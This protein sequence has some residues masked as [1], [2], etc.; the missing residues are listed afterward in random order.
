MIEKVR[1]IAKQFVGN[2]LKGSGRSEV[3]SDVVAIDDLDVYI[4][5]VEVNGKTKRLEFTEEELLERPDSARVKA[6]KFARSI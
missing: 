6:R 2:A 5:V 1:T 4:V 3:V